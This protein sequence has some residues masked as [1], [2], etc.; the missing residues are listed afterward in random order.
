VMVA[1]NLGR[2]AVGLD[3]SYPY[4]HDIARPRTSTEFGLTLDTGQ[5]DTLDDLP[6]FAG[7]L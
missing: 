3:I 7:G 2:R 6:L 5:T 4:L 1:R